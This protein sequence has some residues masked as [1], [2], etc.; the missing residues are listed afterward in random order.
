MNVE[1]YEIN[2]DEWSR[3]PYFS[4]IPRCCQQALIFV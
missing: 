1:F 4:F 2:L 3:T